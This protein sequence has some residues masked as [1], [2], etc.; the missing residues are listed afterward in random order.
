M[1]L[2]RRG[3]FWHYDFSVAGRRYRGAT[4]A[5]SESKARRI[6]SK[7]ISEAEK[8][9]SAAVL[10]RAPLLSEFGPRF[11]SWVN[12]SRG[13][14]PNTRRY[15]RLG[16]RRIRETLLMGMTL[17]RIT[18]ED[19]DALPL[20]GSASYV[21]QVLRTL[22]RLLGKAAEWQVIA[23]TPKIRLLKELGRE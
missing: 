23:V 13:L 15:Y 11:L 14:A 18:N 8:R 7:L 2:Y 4:K 5:T 22:R 12:D 20:D 6:E 17:D 1:A 9:G 10:R 19:V 21:N 16:W 3:K